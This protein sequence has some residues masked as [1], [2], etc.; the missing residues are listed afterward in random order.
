LVGS[1]HFAGRGRI[2]PKFGVILLDSGTAASTGVPDGHHFKSLAAYSVV[3]PVTYAVDVKSTYIRRT[4]LFDLGTDVW[5]FEEYVKGSLQVLANGARSG[6]SV[7]GP[8]RNYAF[9]LGGAASRDM[10]FKGHF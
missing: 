7:L 3:D 5:S 10:K 4:C 2:H 6:R 1:V 9:D 8:P